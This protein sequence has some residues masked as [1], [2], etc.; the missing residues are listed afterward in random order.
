MVDDLV[1]ALGPKGIPKS[2]SEVLKFLH[3]SIDSK[4]EPFSSLSLLLSSL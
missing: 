4:V 1:V 2:K 3:R